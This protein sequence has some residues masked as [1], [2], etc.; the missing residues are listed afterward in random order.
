MS[1]TTAGGAGLPGLGAEEQGRDQGD[2]R[3]RSLGRA[4]GA[5]QAAAG[6]CRGPSRQGPLRG[7]PWSAG[8][9]RRSWPSR[10]HDPGVPG[11][12][13]AHRRGR[14]AYR[15]AA[16][17]RAE[18]G[19]CA[20]LHRAGRQDRPG[21]L[22]RHRTAACR[23]R[24]AGGALH[25]AA[26]ANPRCDPGFLGEPHQ[27]RNVAAHIGRPMSTATGHLAAMRR[28][29]LVVRI[30]P[31]RYKRAEP[32]PGRARRLAVASPGSDGH[33][34]QAVVPV[35]AAPAGAWAGS[36]HEGAGLQEVRPAAPGSP[37]PASAGSVLPPRLA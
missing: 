36:G 3:L 9:A 26:A 5:R 15:C 22:R 29:G 31:G 33:G 10:P 35:R 2:H 30:A 19:G 21:A 11:R 17:H 34:N 12:P 6:G 37:T 18:P 20:D 8:E 28:L 25:L 23:A 27:A 32:M 16:W 14:P 13:P 24:R 7:D 4:Q 1:A